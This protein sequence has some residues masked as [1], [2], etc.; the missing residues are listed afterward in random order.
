LHF[1]VREGQ[2]PRDPMTYL[3]AGATP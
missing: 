2:I 1:E 3:S